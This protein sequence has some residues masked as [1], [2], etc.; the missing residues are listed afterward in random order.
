[1]LGDTDDD[2]DDDEE[3]ALG[4]FTAENSEEK[5]HVPIQESVMLDL[6]SYEKQLD[7]GAMVSILPKTLYDQQINHWLLWSTK[8]KLKAYNGVQIPVY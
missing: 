5:G 1:M 4:L 6:K 3:E 8:V 2:D 7:I